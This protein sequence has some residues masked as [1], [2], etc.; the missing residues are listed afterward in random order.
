M[1]VIQRAT[2]QSQKSYCGVHFLHH[3]ISHSQTFVLISDLNLWM[4]FFDYKFQ[5]S[6]WN[7]SQQEVHSLP[8]LQEK[9]S[10]VCYVGQYFREFIFE[11]VVLHFIV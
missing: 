10:S 1:E 11:I 4:P 8:G 3:P 5:N 7:T 6:P 2:S 9:S